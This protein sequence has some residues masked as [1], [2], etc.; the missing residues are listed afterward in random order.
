M[1]IRTPTIR[2]VGERT[3]EIVWTGLLNGDEGAGVRQLYSDLRLVQVQGTF[4]AGGNARIQGSLVGVVG[5]DTAPATGVA[6]A[7][8]HFIHD[9][10]GNNLD[11]DGAAAN[12]RIEK[13]DEG[14]CWIRP[15]IT[16]GDGTTSLTVR[17]VTR[18]WGPR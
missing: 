8:W 3:S 9:M 7:D 4:G 12:L 6:S 2:Y 16:A 13:I 1:A 11:F 10:Q 5:T 15:V 17:L 14:P 18:D